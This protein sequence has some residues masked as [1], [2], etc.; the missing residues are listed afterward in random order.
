MRIPLFILSLPLFITAADAQWE[1]GWARQSSSPNVEAADNGAVSADGHV[2]VV[3]SFQQDVQIGP[4][5]STGSPGN[6]LRGFVACYDASGTFLWAH[7]ISGWHPSGADTQV[8]DVAI[9]AGNN[10]IVAGIFNDSLLLDGVNVLSKP[11]TIVSTAHV[12]YVLKFGLDGA[13]LWAAPIGVESYTGRLNALAVD[14]NGDIYTVGQGGGDAGRFHKLSGSDG[15]VIFSRTPDGASSAIQDVATD[16][17][18]NVYIVGQ[19]TNAFTM[20]G[21][22]CPYNNALGGGSTPMYVGKFTSAGNALWYYVPD[23]SGS[24]YFGFPE[25]NITVTGDG[26]CFVETR[27][28]VRI[29]GDTLCDGNGTTRGLFAL[30]NNGQ[31][32]WARKL[33]VTGQLAITDIHADSQGDVLIA[34]A[35]YGP[36]VDLLDTILASIGS[37]NVYLARY[38]GT[39]GALREIL[40]NGPETSSAQGIMSVGL[41]AAD[42]PYL[43]GTAPG[44]LQLGGTSITGSWNAF[45][46]RLASTV[47][48]DELAGDG[49][50]AAW[51]DPTD[52]PLWLQLPRS[53]TAWN[54][55][56]SDALGR[57][58]QHLW[59]TGGTVQLNL[60][61]QAKGLYEIVALH[62]ASRVCRR[63]ML[64]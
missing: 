1:Y 14:G 59:T 57:E 23:Q 20:G 54:V 30:D 34:G 63:V 56:I 39:T 15:H 50:P 26:R 47:G 10:V 22:N 53:T 32:I 42:V 36:T 13:L 31:P 17:D 28:H 25:G 19:A 55:H 4:F 62:G 46:T 37:F 38:D 45:V 58:V 7:A 8:R 33:N 35:S 41:D 6:G 44:P 2:A 60:S 12:F 64:E 21:M 11:D 51:P 48:I 27:K 61:G 16:A 24:G 3:G 52:G 49:L 5:T 43:C 29:L 18:N 40:L 9:D